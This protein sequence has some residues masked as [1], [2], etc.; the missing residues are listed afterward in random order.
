MIMTEPNRYG[1]QGICND[2]GDPVCCH[3]V[4]LHDICDGCEALRQTKRKPSLV[5]VDAVR[6]NSTNDDE[7]SE[8][9]L[10]E[11]TEFDDPPTGP[12]G[13]GSIRA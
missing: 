5:G 4:P 3:V 8:N 1:A 12:E 11:L 13:G 7:A 6:M 2:D 9:P 10:A